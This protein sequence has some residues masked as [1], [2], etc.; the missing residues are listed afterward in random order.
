M[1]YLKALEG[2]KYLYEQGAK[3][4][5]LFGSITKPELFMRKSDIDIAVAGLPEE[6]RLSV[7][8]ALIDILY[9]YDFDLIVIDSKDIVAREEI[10]EAVKR[11]GICIKKS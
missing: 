4:V 6:K 1:A 9:P 3:K 5:F 2:A 8:A 11:N 7:E 10:M